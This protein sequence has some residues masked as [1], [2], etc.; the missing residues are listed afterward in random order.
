MHLIISFLTVIL[1]GG[2]GFLRA[3][4]QIDLFEEKKEMTNK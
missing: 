3:T 4:P 1:S 2:T